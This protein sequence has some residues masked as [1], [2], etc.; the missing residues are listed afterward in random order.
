MMPLRKLCLALVLVTAGCWSE[1]SIGVSDRDES[2]AKPKFPSSIVGQQGES[3]T[4]ESPRAGDLD[5]DGLDDFLLLATRFRDDGIAER[6]LLYL[7]YG[8]TDFPA[9]LSTADADAAFEVDGG[10]N[11]PVG[12][13]NGDGLSD[14][15]LTHFDSADFVFGKKQ[16]WHG[17]IERHGTGVTWTI[18]ALPAPFSPAL[19]IYFSVRGVGDLDGDGCADLTVKA[20]A[21]LDAFTG[22][23]AEG[24]WVVRGHEGAWK[25]IEW[26]ARSAVAGLGRGSAAA[27][28]AESSLI[29][30]EPA[31]DLDGDRRDDLMV[32]N[33]NASLLFYGK[34]E[35]P[36]EF[37]IDQADAKLTSE[38]GFVAPVLYSQPLG[39]LDGD[40]RDDLAVAGFGAGFRVAY[41]RRWSG[42]A[43]IEPEL[44]ISF[45][46]PGET[47]VA[48]TAAG[49]L[50]GDGFPE[51]ILNV[52]TQITPEQPFPS[53]AVYVVQGAG[54]RLRGELRL[55][56]ADRW[57]G[58]DS[59]ADP[60]ASGA[61]LMLA[62]DVDGDGGEE[63]L[64]NRIVTD[65]SETLPIYLVPSTPPRVQ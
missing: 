46:G 41:G 51:L 61:H 16:R 21:L 54:E 29:S 10:F 26:D 48:N 27:P 36:A 24:G 7:F 18:G 65:P 15:L 57:H 19:L 9:Q 20:Q 38:Q 13:L 58:L 43:Q 3:L 60:G 55:S 25:S 56:D 62:G 42:D 22:E 12:D 59:H 37:S 11:G 2:A 40:G 50:D 33:G 5:G 63:L 47:Y 31:G 49:D 34:P 23:Q 8:R 44:A 6:P 1:R 45:A 39:D 4:L 52:A 17:L 14:L 53:T 35:Y 64:T 30:T 32:V 28:F